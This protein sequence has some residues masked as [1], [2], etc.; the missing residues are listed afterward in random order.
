EIVYD[1]AMQVSTNPAEETVILVAH[2][3]IDPVDNSKQLKLMTNILEHVQ[4]KGHF[5]DVIPLSLQ[6]DASPEVRAD[7][8]K[9]L[10][11]IIEENTAHDRRVLVV[12][13]LMSSDVIQARV[14]RDLNGLTYTLN[15]N[16]LVEHPY[17]VD[18][19]SET[20]NEQETRDD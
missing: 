16:G 18:W 1:F 7:N 6:D 17:F 9:R 14:E 4:R 3:P 15:T 20:V 12:T 8:V 2:G 5:Y 10:R 13:N 19:I 11:K